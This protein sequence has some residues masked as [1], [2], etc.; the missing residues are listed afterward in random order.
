VQEAIATDAEVNKRGLNARLDVD[1]P[2]FVNVADV[3][4]VAGSLHIKLFE[5]SVF[6]N[7]D[8]AL[9]RLEDVNEHFLFHA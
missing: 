1:D 8:T 9:L 3:A 5:N 4:L 7:G 2:T 6:Q